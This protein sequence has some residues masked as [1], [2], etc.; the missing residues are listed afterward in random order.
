MKGV[1]Q[2]HF[3][4]VPRA[5]IPRSVFDRSHT[6]KQTMEAAGYLYPIMVD[7]VLPG[8]THIVHLDAFCRLAT[9]I[10]PLMDNLYLDTFFFFVPN[11]LVWDNWPKFMGE[12][13]NPG[14]SIDYTVPTTTSISGYTSLGLADYMGIPVGVPNL[15]HNVL[16]LRAYNLIWNEWFRDQNLQQRAVENKDD[17]PDTA[18]DYGPLQRGKRHDYFTSCLP[19]PQKGDAVSLP[20]GTKAYV[21]VDAAV[22]ANPTV[23]RPATGN[24]HYLDSG[25]AQ[26]DISGTTDATEANKLYADLSNATATTINQIRQAFQ[27]Q[28]LQERDAR[29]GTRYTELIRA[30]FGVVSPDQRLQRPEY[31]GGGSTPM[32]ITQVAQTSSTDATT[33]K[34][35]LSAYVTANVMGNGFAKSFTEHGYIL[36]LAMVRADITYQ[37]GLPRM[38]SRSTRYDFYLPALAHIGEQAV[39][40]KEIFAVD[41]VANPGDNDIVF[42]YQ[43]RFGEHRYYPS[44]ICGKFRSDA[45][46][47][48]DFWHLSQDFSVAPTLGDTFIKE[49]PPLDRAIAVTGEPHL[50]FDGHF[51]QKSV[52]PM[53]MFGVP[54]FVDRF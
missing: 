38:F 28:K 23:Q 18:T 34:G 45:T 7:E 35:D 51:R 37:K 5:N 6:R 12:Q 31:L 43:E 47:S 52:R 3:A 17:G 10:V 16:P 22:A 46:G 26:V 27:I 24:F 54:G 21:S 2:S 40:R 19:W 13:R 48:L 33:P 14:D 15:E 44:E 4:E 49:T 36:G 9:P 20:L 39:L 41:E 53:P 42:G 30:H 11:R 1:V 32:N 25:A 50:I 29:G 8:D